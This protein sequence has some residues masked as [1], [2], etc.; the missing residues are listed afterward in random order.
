[1]N[2]LIAALLIGLLALGGNVLAD[3]TSGADWDNSLGDANRCRD[4]LVGHDHEYKDKDTDTVNETY[5]PPRLEYYL[6]YDLVYITDNVPVLNRITDE[7]E[8][9]TRAF[10]NRDNHIR[11]GIGLVGKL[12]LNKETE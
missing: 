5:K 6:G 3:T 9:Q 2:K 8:L 11:G 7:V 12:Y 10:L 4:Y 1:M